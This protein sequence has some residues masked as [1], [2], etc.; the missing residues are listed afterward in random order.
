MT[1]PGPP[2]LNAPSFAP[3]AEVFRGKRGIGLEGKRGARRDDA[4]EHGALGFPIDE[5]GAPRDEEVLDQEMP[6]QFL[7]GHALIL[8]FSDGVTDLHGSAVLERFEPDVPELDGVTL[9]LERDLA[10]A[11]RE[12]IDKILAQPVD[13]SLDGSPP[14]I[15]IRA[16]PFPVRFLIRIR[17]FLDR[18][19]RLAR[20][21]RSPPCEIKSPAN[22]VFNCT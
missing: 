17:H 4:A 5:L 20:R 16:V 3:L 9:H 7:G 8:F 21:E 22:P 6:A 2:R 13:V 19:V 18:R 10:G 14:A 1:S 11:G 12:L 15:D